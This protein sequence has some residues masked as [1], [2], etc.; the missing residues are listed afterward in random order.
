MHNIKLMLVGLLLVLLLGPASAPVNAQEP[1]IDPINLF[2][3]AL[4]RE[5]MLSLTGDV[6][7]NQLFPPRKNPLRR[8]SG[9][10]P[11]PPPI[12]IELLRRNYRASFE[13]GETIAGRATWRVSLLPE[14]PAAP[15]Y[16][17]WFDRAWGVRLASEQL[18]GEGTLSHS[19]R[20]VRL[21]AAPTP[22]PQARK[23]SRLSLRPGLEARV[24]KALPGLN[25]PDG[26]RLVNLARRG[27][28]GSY[29]LEARLS[30]GLAVLVLTLAGDRTAAAP[31][32]VQRQ[33]GRTWLWLVGNLA[34]AQLSR[35]AQSL[36]AQVD[37]PA[38]LQE[39]EADLAVK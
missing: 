3:K 26:F 24:L 5:A 19:A 11:A 34:E 28:P 9:E 27:E 15:S 2:L 37:L 13:P 33:V 14:N 12:A 16:N 4:E 30:N 31:K 38:L 25:L 18:D 21:D 35:V 1:F 8:Y 10:L 17:F 22:R 29:R 7:E 36:S 39:F 32:V 23:L 20:F 6:S